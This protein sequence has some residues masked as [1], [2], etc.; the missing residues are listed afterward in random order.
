MQE[1]LAW[2]ADIE[3]VKC[4]CQK[5]I[6]SAAQQVVKVREE[7][8]QEISRLKAVEVA[9]ANSLKARL[10]QER[11]ARIKQLPSAPHAASFHEHKLGVGGMG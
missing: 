8:A 9:A 5:E 6:E 7:M 10:A 1:R 3:K 11:E 2:Q 4:E